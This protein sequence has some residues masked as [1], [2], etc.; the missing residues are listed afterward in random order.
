MKWI[1]GIHIAIA[2]LIENPLRTF[3][4]L[5]GI[6]IG[7]TAVI[8]V[9]SV[10]EG[11]NGYIG[12]TIGD[13]GPNVFVVQKFGIIKDHKEWEKARQRNKDLN[14][15]DA[16]AIR[17]QASLVSKV[18]PVSGTRS[19]VKYGANSVNDIMVNGVSAE[20]LEIKPYKIEQGRNFMP[21]ELSRAVPLVFLG[22]NVADQ[23]FGRNNPIGRTVKVLERSFTVIGVAEKKGSTF[24][25]PQDNYVLIP[26]TLLHKI[27][28]A[29]RSIEISCMARDPKRLEEAVDEVRALMRARH[30][31]A[32]RDDDDFGILTS[33]GIMQVWRDLTQMIFRVA[34]FVV[35][36]SLV[37]GGIVIM[38]IMLL[39][40]VERTREIGIRKAIGARQQDIQFQFLA[41]SI[42]L[43]ALGGLIG[44]ATAWLGTWAVRT[45]TALP[46][47]FPL[48]APL[49]AVTVTSIV[50]IFFGLHPAHKAAGLDPIDA[51]RS[52]EM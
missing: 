6:T 13:L 35:S 30:H 23:L 19:V 43:C 3:L 33:E 37:V 22:Y 2:S 47:R 45:F 15:A 27:H 34:I 7:V 5:L 10:I 1:D 42:L 38:N 46:A 9:V 12:E 41:E 25:M 40:V 4:T 14:M 32:F 31:L 52:N 24:G 18:A 8:F 17:R 20:A 11:L 39:S 44:V 50:G 36:I 16:A 29:H 21:T 48:W 28:G 26:I 49:L 51:L